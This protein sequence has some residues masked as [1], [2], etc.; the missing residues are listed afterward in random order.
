M[1]PCEKLRSYVHTYLKDAYI[2]DAGFAKWEVEGT[3]EQKAKIAKK[4][5]LLGMKV[6]FVSVYEMYVAY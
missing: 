1:T 5:I 3:I 4:A 6:N 2:I